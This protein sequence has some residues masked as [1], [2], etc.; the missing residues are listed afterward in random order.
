MVYRRLFALPLLL[1]AAFA[2]GRAYAG[3]V[4]APEATLPDTTLIDITG[5]IETGS[6]SGGVADPVPLFVGSSGPV[7]FVMNAN[8]GEE[9]L[10]RAHQTRI[11][12]NPELN[13]PR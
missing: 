1:A 3:D 4:P 6:L 13:R 7:V 10:A 8:P 12:A 2:G 11:R 9:A 5:E